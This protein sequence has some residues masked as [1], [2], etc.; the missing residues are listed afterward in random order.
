MKLPTLKKR[1][2]F[3]QAR[4][5]GTVCYSR[6]FLA[7]VVS[8]KKLNLS[9]KMIGITCSS[10]VGN[11]VVR[12]RTKRRMR[13]LLAQTLPLLPEEN[14]YVFIAKSAVAQAQFSDIERDMREL[15]RKIQQTI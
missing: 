3:V 12:N 1:I 11:A 8:Q 14:I 6:Y 10:K 9:E 7:Q 15:L 13:A 4:K 5:F 2:F